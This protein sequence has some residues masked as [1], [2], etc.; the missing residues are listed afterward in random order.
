MALSITKPTVG[1]SEDSWGDTNNNALD[2]IVTEINSN[3]DGT[4]A[5][6]PNFT[7]G[8]WQ[9]G[10]TAVTSSAAELNVLDGISANLSAAE[11]S[12]LDGVTA[13]TTQINILDGATV[14]TAEL[15][16]LASSGINQSRMTELNNFANT[17]TLPTTD[18]SSG[19]FLTTNGSGNLSFATVQ[20]GG[21]YTAGTGIDISAS[22][23]I[24]VET[25]LRDGITA[26]GRD[27]NDYMSIGTSSFAWYINGN[28]RLTLDSSG[29]LVADGNVTAYSD[30]RLK[31]DVTT[32]TNALELVGSMRGVFFQ[33]DGM[34]GTGV[35]AQEMEQVMPEVV[36]HDGE[37]M[38]V[39]YGNIVGVL[40]EA[41][42][43][44]K[45]E[46]EALKNDVTK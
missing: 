15:N 42:K 36:H 41:I 5:T 3:A 17:F 33:K 37:Y 30:A 10:G 45:S 25:D 20:S 9:I 14:T 7:E 12:I 21:T 13:T 8:S 27:G 31:T 35:I 22:N 6:T 43:E 23:V 29:N 40:I 32:I 18:G 11:L 38:S 34:A 24:S 26:V 16:A 46:I 44:L 2:A 1:G 39:A 4:N 19:Q 28:S